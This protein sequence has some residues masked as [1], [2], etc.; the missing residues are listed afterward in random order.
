MSARST[1]VRLTTV[2]VLTLGAAILGPAQDSWRE[3][4]DGWPY[5]YEASQGEGDDGGDGTGFTSLDGTWSH[6]NGSDQ[7]D[8]S[9]F[10]G[11]APGGV[12]ILEGEESESFLRLQDPGDPRSEGFPDPGSNRKLYFG[13]DITAEGAS[14]TILDD[15]VTLNFR[16]RVPT[17]DGDEDPIDDLTGGL[18]YPE[19]GDG[20][21]LHNGGKGSIG[22]KQAGGGLVSFALTTVDDVTGE[23]LIFN[24]ETNV[25]GDP[26]AIPLDPLEWNEFWVTIEAD[27]DAI[28]FGTHLVTVYMNGE[29][30][31][32]DS[33]PVAT[34]NGSDF[35]GISYLAIGLGATPFSGALDVDF[36]RWAPEVLEPD[37]ACEGPRAAA[38][39]TIDR[40]NHFPGDRL[41]VTIAVT[42]V[43][44]STRISDT[45]P[46][47]FAID[48]ANGGAV[49]G[50]TIDFTLEADGDVS[51][52]VLAN[53]D[54]GDCA[55]AAFSGEAVLTNGCPVAIEGDSA[56]TNATNGVNVE[57]TIDPEIHGPGDI[58]TVTL[59]IT[60]IVSE[61]TITE[62]LSSGVSVEDAAGGAA[63]GNT[64]TFTAN[65]D[66]EIVY[67]LLAGSAAADC[68]PGGSITGVIAPVGGCESAVGG[69][70]SLRCDGS[71][72]ACE[73]ADDAV[74]AEYVVGFQF[75]L[76][77]STGLSCESESGEAYIMVEQTSP[78]DVEYDLDRGWGF[79]VLD[80]GNGGR[81]GWAQ[82]GPFDDS[83]NNRNRFVSDC[84]EEIYD[85]FIGFKNFSVPC[86]ANTVGGPGE[87]NFD[88]PC[89]EGGI[90]PEGGVFRID[91]EEEGCYR[92][93]AIIGDSDNPHAHRVLVED[94][95]EGAP[96]DIGP[97][98][99]TLV[100]NFDQN[101]E[102]SGQVKPDCLGC[103]VFARVGFD[104]KLPPAGDGIE[105][106]P[107]FVNMDED[108]L[109]T[110]ACPSSPILEVSEG[111]VRVHLLQGNANVGPGSKNN[112]T[113]VDANGGD[114]VL[115]EVW[116]LDDCPGGKE[117]GPLFR[118]G[119]SDTNGRLELTDSVF[120]LNFLFLGG[121]APTCSESADTDDNGRVEL[122]DGVFGLNFLFL[123]GPPPPA[124][125]HE[126]C[127]EDPA[128]SIAALGC[129]TNN[130]CPN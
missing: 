39:R 34:G 41:T 64:I 112:G 106:D 119:D 30:D 12:E 86:N 92:F 128:D 109:P 14:G 13:H 102:E 33:F 31:P 4:E 101:Q 55:A 85:S 97:N 77:P 79:V 88:D 5:A 80:P 110:G 50:R 71:L 78:F 32:L 37:N 129:E 3:P 48:N 124:P 2:S 36:F 76:L 126:S 83:P 67:E 82:F 53:D 68:L 61:T 63:E 47:G 38:T 40:P 11:G 108:G 96:V 114:I 56:V 65:A 9:D 125:G 120:V 73:P 122:T 90:D 49:N 60:G 22:I 19:T 105:P 130:S 24:G 15:G 127:G 104:D 111:Y 16:V 21:G 94:G 29:T 103:G 44:A 17:G 35:G 58:I 6:D 43:A 26:N 72:V 93:V 10:A 74:E 23:A 98:F 99:V 100:N 81:G 1:C 117:P 113:A 121:P 51:Y 118:R 115:F 46:E 18:P 62:T 107:Q 70:E 87:P 27:I 75:G 116:R 20:Y 91:L 7:W 8:G 84:P 66:G 25:D 45:F 89:E 54:P 95:G 123:G 42:G 52:T 57:R 69:S 28:G 59:A